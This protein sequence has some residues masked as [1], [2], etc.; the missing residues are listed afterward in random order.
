MIFNLFL[1][2][3]VML[4]RGIDQIFKYKNQ[5]HLYE[6]N[7]KNANYY[8]PENIVGNTFGYDYVWGK[9]LFEPLFIHADLRII[10]LETSITVEQLPF[11]NKMVH[12]KMHPKNVDA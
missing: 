3:D 11:P 2:G 4:G 12:Y 7:V 8:V 5:P 9:L 10:N 1:C 6:S